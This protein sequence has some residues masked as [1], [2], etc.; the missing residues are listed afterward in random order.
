MATGSNVFE[1][2]LRLVLE[3]Q[4]QEGLDRLRVA[5]AEVGDVSDETVAQTTKLIDGL[6]ELNRKAGAAAEFDAL[7]ESIGQTEE[8][9]DEAQ[10]R[11]YQLT[12]ALGATE[13]PS[14]ELQKAQADAKAEVERLEKAFA[15]QW[16]GL[17][18]IE[19][20]LSAAGVDTRNLGTLQQDLRAQV[21]D[22]TAAVE[23]QA[24]AVKDEATAQA[25]LKQRLEE[26][27]EQFRKQAKASRDAAESL[28]AYRAR[29]AAAD[30]QTRK[31]VDSIRIVDSTMGRLRGLLAGVAGLF[32]FRAAVEGTKNILGLG[33]AAE[34]AR[35]RL[36]RLY[37]AG[38]G[39]AAF[40]QIRQ[41]ARD[42]GAQF[43]AMLQSALKLKT[44]GLEPLDGTL[45]GLIDQNALLGGS[46]ESLDG[47]I[48]AVGQAW[49]KQKLQGEEIMQLVERGV[50]VWDLLAKATGKNVTEL[51]RLSSA[52]Q[53]GKDVIRELL[54]EMAKSSS[55]AAADSIN[56]LSRLWTAFVDRV[57]GFARDIA[58]SGALD[59]F[60]RQLSEISAAIDAMAASG[61]LQRY[62]KRVSD[63]IVGIAE[64]IKSTTIF[65]SQHTTALVA[66]GRAYAAL[67]LAKWAVELNALRQRWTALAGA[68]LES[69]GAFDKAAGRASRMGSVLKAIPTD[70]RIAVLLVGLDLAIA[71]AKKLGEALGATS[72]A[73]E[74]L[75]RVQEAMREQM[76]R[77]AQARAEQAAQY[78]TY[79]DQLVLTAEQVSKMSAEEVEAYRQRLDGLRKY[80]AA[81]YGYLLRQKELGL[82]TQEQLAQL[83]QLPGRLK[84][85]RDGFDDVAAGVNRAADAL[86][87][88]VSP[89]AQKIIDQ[90]QGID[91]DAKSAAASIK[92]LFDGLNFAEDIKLGDVGL[93]LASIASQSAGAN[94]NVRDGLLATLEQL[95]GDQLARF[96][97]AATA[98]FDAFNT[99]PTQAAAIL[100]STLYA[101]LEKLGVSA[102]RM[103][104]KFTTAGRDAVAAFG[105]IVENANATSQQ[106][107]AAFNAALGKVSTLD[108]AR[109]LGEVLRSAG[110]QGR[111]GFDQAERSAA[112]LS[113]RISGITAAMDPLA[114]AFSALGIQSQAA[115]NAAR[116][117]SKAAFDAIRQGAASGKASVD[118]VRRALDAYSRTAKAAVA[119]S[120][121]TAKARVES[122]LAVLDAI[123]K[124]NDN[125]D[126][127]GRRGRAAGKGIRQG[128]DEA[129]AALGQTAAAA[130]Q[131][132]AA[133]GEAAEMNINAA[134]AMAKAGASASALTFSLGEVSQA[135][136]EA[137]DQI[138]KNAVAGS[139]VVQWFADITNELTRQREQVRGLIAEQQKLLATYDEDAQRREQLRKQYE[140]VSDS[141]IE[142][143]LQT[144]K[145][146]KAAEEARVQRRRQE[147]E[148]QR[149]EDLKR[150][151]AAKELAKAQGDATAAA[152]GGAS[153]GEQT[154]VIDWR[155]PSRDA[156]AGATAA[157]TAQ[158]ERMAAMVAPLVLR[159]L[160][161]SRAISNVRIKPR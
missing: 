118:D 145:Q 51:Q 11:A 58:N 159:K 17:L 57:Q 23:R 33:D 16:A 109:A 155:A 86:K 41:L 26:G 107:E 153:G 83:A 88:S 70:I 15:G 136:M 93:A 48:L 82:A 139:P 71:G 110:E 42:S 76:R 62:A 143:L 66:I 60:K 105:A 149:Q 122:E 85:V 108:D 4:G 43:D 137:F 158:A 34:I 69:A 135:W 29:T 8:Q 130:S 113:A 116:D 27:D 44:F 144:E 89:A 65:L 132:A 1:E 31:L 75:G 148:A 50:P 5:L 30:A 22:A 19:G 28:E 96:Q 38:N 36:D 79:R 99:A 140:F 77:E 35:K 125:L 115:L 138:G 151:D 63:A 18:K 49:S 94:K 9:L 25:Q 101:A 142:Q 91:A 127:M 20:A 111:I 68:A 146:V 24:R 98:A 74:E 147:A 55:G 53:L 90:L 80:L 156:A 45:K 21:A 2:V 39:Q 37:G 61:D 126:D 134:G 3:T 72:E 6:A 46:M 119:D 112:A 154:L 47:I 104:T 129:S 59:Y 64:A 56:T 73:A 92:K 102:D 106:V 103:G 81:Q 54:D 100:E 14:R 7:S 95:T 128:A 87:T 120:D 123:Y 160:Q 97:A 124:V 32:S 114:D 157:E 10:K 40:D 152:G 133:S 67:K 161:Q 13:K 121:S 52:G 84:A 117:A 141:E 12:L 131:A 150:I 78:A